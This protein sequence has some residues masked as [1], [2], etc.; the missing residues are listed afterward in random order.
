MKRA[1]QG[2]TEQSRAAAQLLLDL[3]KYD[4]AAFAQACAGMARSGATRM[5]PV[6]AELPVPEKAL[7]R[8]CGALAK[9]DSGAT[10]IAPVLWD[11]LARRRG[12]D[13]NRILALMAYDEDW[14][15]AGLA[16][17][18]GAD[19]CALVPVRGAGFEG[20]VRFAP[21]GDKYSAGVSAVT[22][23]GA[24]LLGNCNA[25]RSA[26]LA[27]GFGVLLGRPYD[28]IPAVCE[29]DR[30]GIVNAVELA[31]MR[32]DLEALEV[33]LGALDP[34]APGV[35]EQLRRSWLRLIS[36]KDDAEAGFSLSQTTLSRMAAILIESGMRLRQE[37]VDVFDR[38]F[39]T[40]LV[41][42]LTHLRVDATYPEAALLAL[43]TLHAGGVCITGAFRKETLLHR[44]AALHDEPLALLALTAGVDAGL[45]DRSGR[46]AL[47]LA[48][49]RRAETVAAIIRA[50]DARN[51]LASI[52]A[53]TRH[54]AQ[55]GAHP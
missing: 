36:L 41:H 43:E 25:I 26:G 39:D 23:F 55:G 30:Y 24:A 53:L 5:L 37:D 32:N 42:K 31:G 21:G 48:E 33:V 44:A 13:A 49:K 52:A 12:F 29:T 45:K 20:R 3:A 8:L 50:H 19:P 35:A 27:D 14:A 10:E 46:T 7:R 11:A 17:A 38:A 28:S 51:V 9:P 18:A 1:G 54:H 15:G 6:L 16:V 22:G 47:V 4:P 34:D 2:N 40:S